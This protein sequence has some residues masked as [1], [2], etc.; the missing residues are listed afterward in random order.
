MS[1]T[2]RNLLISLVVVIMMLV[3]LPNSQKSAD[4]QADT[5]P[6]MAELIKNL[7]QKTKDI[8]GFIFNIQFVTPLIENQ[9]DFQIPFFDASQH[10]NRAIDTIGSDYVCFREIAGGA[11]FERCTPFS[12]IAEIAYLNN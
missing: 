2:S 3:V 10:L 9:P 6:N 7:N 1:Q 4:A 12:N 11:D 8:P 5:A